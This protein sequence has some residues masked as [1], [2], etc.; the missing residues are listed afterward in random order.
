MTQ[1]DKIYGIIDSGIV[2]K[3]PIPQIM[4]KN[5]ETMSLKLGI[6]NALPPAHAM[7]P[8]VTTID[9]TPISP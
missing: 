1:P 2:P 5:A 4:A 7:P 9:P 3:P 6:P 8:K